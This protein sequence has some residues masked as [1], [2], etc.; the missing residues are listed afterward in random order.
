M[1][2]DGNDP[3]EANRKAWDQAAPYHRAHRHADLLSRFAEPG[4]SCLDD[5][6]TERLQALGVQGKALAQL[7]CN[8]GR[9]VLSARNLGA[10]ARRRL[11]PGRGVHRAGAGTG[12]GGLCRLRVRRD[13]R[14]PD[15]G[16]LRRCVRHCD[17]HYRRVRMDAGS[18]PL[19]RHRRAI[20]EAGRLFLRL[21]AA[22]HRRDIRAGRTGGSALFVFSR[23]SRSWK[24]RAWTITAMPSTRR[25]PTIGSTIPWPTS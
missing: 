21:R 24:P 20:A 5:I 19:S 10:A 2:T 23:A 8:N 16:R 1:T 18:E 14:Q 4:Y 9:E 17:G 6:A 13:G 25:K 15:R 11:R 7:C 12:G 3:V 22:P